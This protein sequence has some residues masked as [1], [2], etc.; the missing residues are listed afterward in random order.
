ML[1]PLKNTLTVYNF[2]LKKV[3]ARALPDRI[4]LFFYGKLSSLKTFKKNILSPVLHLRYLRHIA[5]AIVNFLVCTWLLQLKQIA[6]GWPLITSRLNSCA[7][8]VAQ[9]ATSI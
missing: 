8:Q 4:L 6:V 1:E 9:H 3:I 2:L 7:S 5:K